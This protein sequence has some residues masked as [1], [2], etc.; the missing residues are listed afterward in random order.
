MIRKSIIVPI[1]V[2]VIENHGMIRL[3][4]AIEDGMPSKKA[5]CCGRE[6]QRNLLYGF[7]I[8]VEC[9]PAEIRLKKKCKLEDFPKRLQLLEKSFSFAG[10][11][12][13]HGGRGKRSGHYIRYSYQG[14]KWVEFDDTQK[15]V[16]T[17]SDA[18]EFDPYLIVYISV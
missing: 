12:V 4:D 5:V 14:T 11:V 10:V 2:H 17:N 9:D 1:N 8:I 16:K 3:A 13:R 6:K 7:Q 15:K 18:F